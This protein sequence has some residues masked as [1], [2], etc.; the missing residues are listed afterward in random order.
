MSCRKRFNAV[1]RCRNPR[2]RTSHWRAGITCGTM[3][4]GISRSVPEASPYT[5]NVMPTRGQRMSAAR[6]R[7]HR[8]EAH[9]FHTDHAPCTGDA[10]IGGGAVGEGGGEVHERMVA[11]REPP[12]LWWIRAW[13]CRIFHK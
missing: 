3:S 6:L 4:N 11:C 5:A 1:T 10:P 7:F 8:G 9:E 13:T 12:A 2:A